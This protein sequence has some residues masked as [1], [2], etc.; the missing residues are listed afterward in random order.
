MPLPLILG[1]GAA[2]AAITGV[3]AGIAGGVKMKDAN[4]TM[5]LAKKIQRES[6]ERYEEQSKQTTAVMDA[7]GEKELNI[8][9]SFERFTDR[10]EKIKNK[11]HIKE[12][13]TEKYDIPQFDPEEIRQVS[14]GASVLVG[15]L[16]CAAV[17]TA[18]GFAAAGATTAAVM[19]F[20][21][22]S[23]GTAIAS[24]S[25]AAAT[26]ATLAALGGGA[27]AAGGGGMALG[28]VVL[29]STTVG[30]GLLVGGI[31]FSFTGFRLSEKADEAYS[32]AKK[33]ADSSEKICAF[34]K[35]LDGCAESCTVSLI[36][37][38]DIY[39]SKLE[40]FEGVVDKKTDW[41]L[42]S[43]E[44]RILTE[45]LVLLVGLL[46]KMCKVNI[47]VKSENDEEPN[48][49]NFS[50]IDKATKDAD[51]IITELKNV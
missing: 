35:E 39:F 43:Q 2:I 24:L 5:G 19:A 32:Q 13:C 26:N 11:P 20:G 42:F 23:T 7:L 1:I 15:G 48:R 17:S 3:S 28:S 38:E 46:H 37:V 51:K 4:D 25:G 50:N 6:I 9:K 8:L 12:I 34:L 22:A 44:E 49:V 18:G 10:F 29:S 14:V 33:T 41:T 30:I 47:V 21:T 27:I 31:I 40:S 16:G 36:K 45:N